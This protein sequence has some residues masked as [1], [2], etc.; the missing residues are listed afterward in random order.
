MYGEAAFAAA[1]TDNCRRAAQLGEW[2][3]ASPSMALGAPVVS[4]ICVFSARADLPG[5]TQS[6]L[7]Q[8]IAQALQASGEAVFSTTEV[9][10]VS[11]L[12]A[13]ITNHRTTE[14]D[15]ETAMAAVDRE[16]EARSAG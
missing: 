16:A 14:A 2:V 4:N 6:A 13:A 15:I 8:Q 3:A 11:L 10:G 7:N 12:R 1:I 5:P 9:G